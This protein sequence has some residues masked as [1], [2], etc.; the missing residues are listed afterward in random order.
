MLIPGHEIIDELE[1]LGRFTPASPF[2]AGHMGKTYDTAMSFVSRRQH[3]RELGD[4]EQYLDPTT[5]AHESLHAMSSLIRNSLG[6]SIDKGYDVIYVG[7]GQ[8][9]EIRMGPGIPKG[10]IAAWVPGG[11]GRA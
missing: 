10:E 2:Y 9:A 3:Y 4:E 1:E 8:F 7:D 11:R 5:E 6:H